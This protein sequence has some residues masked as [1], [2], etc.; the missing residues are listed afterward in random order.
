MLIL[1]I[2]LLVFVVRSYMLLQKNYESEKLAAFDL[3]W[4]EIISFGYV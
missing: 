2:I 3:L 1:S 4:V